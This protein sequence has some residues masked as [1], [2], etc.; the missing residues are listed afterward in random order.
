MQWKAA[1]HSR[2][3]SLVG[4]P[5]DEKTAVVTASAYS[6]VYARALVVRRAMEHGAVRERSP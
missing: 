5:K 2:R 1:S 4:V 3:D 6:L